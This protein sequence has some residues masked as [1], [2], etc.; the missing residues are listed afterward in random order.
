MGEVFVILDHRIDLDLAETL[1]P[2]SFF[3]LSDLKLAGLTQPGRK[4][5]YEWSDSA[6]Q[7]NSIGKKF[8]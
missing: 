5:S 6:N 7:Y 4:E 1:Y 3:P 2:G 8:V